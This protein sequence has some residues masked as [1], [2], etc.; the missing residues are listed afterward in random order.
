[1]Y[2]GD[3]SDF[4]PRRVA[5]LKISHPHRPLSAGVG[6][7]SVIKVLAPITD[8][9]YT[10]PAGT[11]LGSTWVFIGRSSGTALSV[12]P[13]SPLG[14]GRNTWPGSDPCVQKRRSRHLSRRIKNTLL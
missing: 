14:T 13:R 12:K 2:F 5:R 6:L 7:D 10:R 3:F 8:A 4:A 9:P 11:A 1:M